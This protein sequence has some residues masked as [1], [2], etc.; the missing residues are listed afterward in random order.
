MSTYDL[1]DRGKGS[2]RNRGA[3]AIVDRSRDDKVIV[4]HKMSQHI[5]VM[6]SITFLTLD[7]CL[8]PTIDTRI[9]CKSIN[10][11]C[12]QFSRFLPTGQIRGYVISRI[13]YCAKAKKM[14]F[15]INQFIRRRRIILTR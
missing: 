14:Y 8:F 11:R 15:S 6:I 7:V 13:S 10:C 2:G 5:L 9:Y 12:I 4:E 3:Q 1:N